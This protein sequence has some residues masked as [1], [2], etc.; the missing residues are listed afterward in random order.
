MPEITMENLRL[1]A[2]ARHCDNDI[3]QLKKEIAETAKKC[4]DKAALDFWL[5][6]K[7][8]ANEILLYTS[9]AEWDGY[10]PYHEWE[11]PDDGNTPVPVSMHC[12]EERKTGVKH[13]VEFLISHCAIVLGGVIPIP[14]IAF[15]HKHMVICSFEL[16]IPDILYSLP[17]IAEYTLDYKKYN[18]VILKSNIHDDYPFYS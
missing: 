7:P 1:G 3:R 5:N 12:I 11:S 18:Y 2:V 8:S 6:W 4:S 15:G 13:P 9:Y 10:K 16:T 14:T 17:T